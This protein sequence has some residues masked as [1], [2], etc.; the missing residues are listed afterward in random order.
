MGVFYIGVLISAV[1]YGVCLLQAFIYFQ[2]K[3][4]SS[5]CRE[6]TL[7]IITEFARDPWF[8]RAAVSLLITTPGLSNHNSSQVITLVT[9]DTAHLIFVAM[10]GEL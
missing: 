6:N 5:I 9:L 3:L 4:P 2:S 10:G 8:T 1:L 7:N